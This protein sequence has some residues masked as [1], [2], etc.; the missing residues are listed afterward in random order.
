MAWESDRRSNF[1]FSP[2]AHL[3]D[4]TYMTEISLIMTLNN[5][6]NQL[7]RQAVWMIPTIQWCT[8]AVC[9]LVHATGRSWHFG[10]ELYKLW[11]V[12]MEVFRVDTGTR[13][14]YLHMTKKFAATWVQCHEVDP[15]S[16]QRRHGNWKQVCI[17]KSKRKTRNRSSEERVGAERR[18]TPAG[19][20]S[21]GC[22]IRRSGVVRGAKRGDTRYLKPRFR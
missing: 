3:C 5:H 2:P 7:F 19:N 9:W 8:C 1:Y 4:V 16:S 21:G 11:G 17:L 6:F 14:F 15:G 13:R 18:N 12:P 10:A 20:R 22:R